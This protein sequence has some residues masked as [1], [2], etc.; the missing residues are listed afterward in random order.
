VPVL[1]ATVERKPL[2]VTLKTVGN[3]LPRNS[4]TVKS[5][6][7]GE[8]T[9]VHFKEGQEVEKDA[10]L[11]TIDSRPYDVALAKSEADLEKA[12]A[13][14]IDAQVR[15][16]SFTNLQNKS[17]GSV[18]KDEVNRMQAGAAS[19]KADVLAAEAAVKTAKLQIEYCSIKSPQAG[20]T[21]SVLV[22]AGNVITANTT[23]LVVVNE[24][25][26][27][28]VTFSLAGQY[29]GD[30]TYYA[31][32]GVLKVEATPEGRRS[33]TASGEVVF[34]NNQV[35]RASGTIELR[36]LFQNTE[37]RLWPGQFAD[38]TLSLTTEPDRVVAP[39]RAV[40]TGQEGTFV[41]VV[42]DDLTAAVQAVKV[43]RTSGDEVV[44]AEGLKGGE[45]VVIDGQSQLAEGS[46]VDI[47][48]S[49]DA[50]LAEHP[51]KGPPPGKAAGKPAA[52][53]T[54]AGKP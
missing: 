30:I 16:K 7:G 40:Q 26:P 25:A 37:R 50:V 43:A 27:V 35:N 38:V 18:S 23:D 1:V 22:D 46:K 33:E 15:S 3:V 9:G 54:P 53:S 51:G 20:R 6:V 14:E 52:Q 41:F 10:L 17:G 24:M 31:Q 12:K 39:A 19:A 34:I 21:G 42:K 29:L 28:E 8:I 48:P 44:I 2:P 11:F 45:R 13:M 36:A 49:L 4:V 5:K 32:Q 47:K